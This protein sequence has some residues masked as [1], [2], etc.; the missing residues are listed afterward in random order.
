MLLKVGWGNFKR[1]RPIEERLISWA[2]VQS[3]PTNERPVFIQSVNSQSHWPISKA[4]C[5]SRSQLGPITFSK[6]S[7]IDLRILTWMK[8]KQVHS[9]TLVWNSWNGVEFLG[10]Y[11]LGLVTR[12][13]SRSGQILS[14]WLYI[15]SAPNCLKAW[16]VQCCLWYCVL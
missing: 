9:V 3:Q 10:Q 8:W 2:D 6:S 5:W 16:S 7:S 13:E 14:S 11:R 4:C 15:Y 1:S 12:L